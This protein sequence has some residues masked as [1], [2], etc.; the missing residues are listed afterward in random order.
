[1]A[2]NFPKI[3]RLGPLR[4]TL[5]RS[6]LGYSWGLPGLRIGITANGRRL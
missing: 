3:L 2:W 1:M 4:G 6:G 5:A